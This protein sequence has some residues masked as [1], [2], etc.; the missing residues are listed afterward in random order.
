V[1]SFQNR[2]VTEDDFNFEKWLKSIEVNLD[3][4]ATFPE[5]EMTISAKDLPIFYYFESPHIS[6]FKMFFWMKTVLGYEAYQEEKFRPELMPKSLL[7]LGKRIH[8]KYTCLSRTELWS[9]DTIHAS[10]RQIEFYYDCSF[11]DNASQAQLLCDELIQIIRQIRDCASAG[12]TENTDEPFNLFKNEILIA[13]NTILF[14]MGPKRQI[15]INHNTLNVLSTTQESFCIQTENYLRNL[16][17]KATKIS[18]T[19]EKDRLKFFNNIEEKIR[20]LKNR[21][22]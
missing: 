4:I 5:R 10:I 19:S 22:I 20:A 16:L 2:F 3:M 13:D 14:K 6:A 21:M 18:G 17:N 7:A 15:F 12:R 8:E 1:V 9:D 11:F